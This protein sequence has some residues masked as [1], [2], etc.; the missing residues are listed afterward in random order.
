[1]VDGLKDLSL[2]NQYRMTPGSTLETVIAE[3][4]WID[5]IQGLRAKCRSLENTPDRLLTP[6]DLP[7]WNYD[8]SSCYQATTENSEVTLKPVAV[9]KDPF[10][11]PAAGNRHHILVMCESYKWAD[12]GTYSQFTPANTNFRALA[13]PIFDAAAGEE[14][15]YGIEQEYTLIGTMTKFTTWPLGWPNNGYPGAQGPYYC[16]VGA[17]VCFGRVISDA[18]YRACLYAG[19]KCSG[20][21]GEVMPGQWEYQI[22]PCEGISI[23]DHMYMSRYILARVAE[24]YNVD[25][26]FEPKLFPDW[27]GSGC[28]TNYSTKIMREGSGGMAYIEAMMEKMSAKHKLHLS[29]YGTDNEKRLTG[30]HET[31][32]MDTF[33]YGAGNRAA[34]VRI[35]TSTA[36]AGGKGY[37]ED[38]RP[39]SNIDAYV[40]CA[41][42]LDTTTLTGDLASPM[43]HAYHTYLKERSELKI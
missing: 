15:W 26:S 29:C 28:H 20:T 6:E 10:R 39:A 5:G 27:N 4:V 23:G 22:G 38:R 7:E 14:S 37:I 25:V 40:V 34:S 11:G 30:L 8:G 3:Y 35:P 16:S 36:Q 12:P 24:D 9:F 1:M 18:H 43:V 19:I 13:K 32:S 2:H 17:N 21:N 42:I 31:S 41:L 33:S